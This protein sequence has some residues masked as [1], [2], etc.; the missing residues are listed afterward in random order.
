[1]A[2]LKAKAALLEKEAWGQLAASLAGSKTS[3]LW[4]LLQ[5]VFGDLPK[6]KIERSPPSKRSHSAYDLSTSDSGSTVPISTPDI[7]QPISPKISVVSSMDE[8]SLHDSGIKPEYP[9][10]CGKTTS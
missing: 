1:M 10:T 5:G 4:D 3:G 9:L 6:T 2:T 7:T 8:N